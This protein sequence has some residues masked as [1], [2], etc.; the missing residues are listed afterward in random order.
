MERVEAHAID[1][2]GRAFDVPDG[3]VAPSAGFQRADLLLFLEDAG[4]RALPI[5]SLISFLVGTI[6]AYMGAAQLAMFGAQIYIANLVGVGM[7]RGSAVKRLRPVGSTSVRPRAG[8]PDGPGATWRPSRA[9]IRA[10]RSRAA[11]SIRIASPV[12]SRP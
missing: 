9:A 2:F 5:V 12:S 8:A 1:K 3:K 7:V 10:A 6:L 4:P 11:L